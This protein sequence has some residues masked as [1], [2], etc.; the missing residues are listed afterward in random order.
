MIL[1]HQW[2]VLSCQN[3]FL[4]RTAYRNLIF[5]SIGFRI[6]EF[7]RITRSAEGLIFDAAYSDLVFLMAKAC[8]PRW[9]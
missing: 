3:P 7:E 6:S 5:L 8:R 2:F 9:G 1:A 4:S